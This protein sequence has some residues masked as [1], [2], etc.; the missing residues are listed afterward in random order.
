MEYIDQNKWQRNARTGTLTQTVT[1]S[2]FADWS[3]H[4]DVTLKKVNSAG[5]FRVYDADY[6]FKMRKWRNPVNWHCNINTI[7]GGIGAGNGTDYNIRYRG[8]VSR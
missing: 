2:N 1:P 6:D 8:V 5:A 4:G 3:V 7:I